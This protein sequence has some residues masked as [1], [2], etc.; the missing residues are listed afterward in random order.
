MISRAGRP[1]ED[2]G[3]SEE[4]AGAERPGAG[5]W[6]VG[7]PG[8]AASS[9]RSARSVV[10]CGG[11]DPPLVPLED[12]LLLQHPDQRPRVGIGDDPGLCFP[13]SISGEKHPN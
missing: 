2:A 11:D 10:S 8:A 7:T 12:V 6:P 9:R 13:E 5:A 4:G 3:I 1:L